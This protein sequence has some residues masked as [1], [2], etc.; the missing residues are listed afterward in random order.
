MTETAA[1]PLGAVTVF[2]GSRPGRRPAYHQAASELGAALARRGTTLVYGGAAVGLMGALAD[3]ALGAGGHVI[4]VLPNGLDR[5]EIAHRDVSDL[6]VVGS[7]H[8]RKA[9]MV[10]LA[11]AFVALPGGLGT[12][13]ELFECL[14]WAQLGLHHRPIGL[15]EVADYFA[16]LLATLD[17]AV[18]EDFLA[19]SRR[20]AV[21]VDGDACR[22]LDRLQSA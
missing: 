15:L 21:L 14:T 13:D 4:G 20:D 22:L 1:D 3:G 2:C 7:M 6:R 16:P 9:L 5:R 8:E 18:D 17:R 11:D 12:F 19:A 10:D